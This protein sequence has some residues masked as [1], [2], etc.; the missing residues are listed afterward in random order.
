MPRGSE[1]GRHRSRIGHRSRQSAY[2]DVNRKW[3]NRKWVNPDG[4]VR[5]M[6]RGEVPKPALDPIAG[7]GVSERST[8]D[9]ADAWT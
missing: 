3:V 7:H 6:G 9:E 1:L 4:G 2:H 5:H 8:D